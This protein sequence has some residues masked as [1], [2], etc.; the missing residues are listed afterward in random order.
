MIVLDLRFYNGKY[1]GGVF[2]IA[3]CVLRLAITKYK[4][5]TCLVQDKKL[6]NHITDLLDDHKDVRFTV[7]PIVFTYML[8]TLLFGAFFL[9]KSCTL[10]FWPWYFCPIIRKPNV[11]YLLG[12]WDITP[13]TYND[14]Y[15]FPVKYILPWAFRVSAFNASAIFACSKYDVGLIEKHLRPR[16]PV[17]Y[18]P[19]PIDKPHDI[20]NISCEKLSTTPVD[21]TSYKHKVLN[22]VSYGN[23]YDRRMVPFLLEALDI[24][25]STFKLDFKFILVGADVTSSNNIDYLCLSRYFEV[26]RYNY[27]SQD[28][29]DALLHDAD[30]GICLSNQ[31]GTSYILLEL[32][33]LN[34][35]ILTTSLMSD[36]VG[37]YCITLD[38]SATAFEL[39]RLI[40]TNYN[41]DQ[42]I[43][44]ARARSEKARRFV[45]NNFP[46][47]SGE[48]VIDPFDISSMTN[49]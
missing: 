9:P 3:I 48:N 1:H 20:N 15:L 5:V 45:I 33:L 49:K 22:F 47:S 4:S 42:S 10:A 16:A 6:V 46:D 18:F 21:L 39:A 27:L 30:M 43:L 13:I 19:L 34:I 8:D 41:S 7:R 23:I 36:E 32:A 2:R 17:L 28:K 12:M 37:G 26:N 38:P 35:P 44:S 29:L 31:D 40:F 14:S 24:L 25:A 11:S